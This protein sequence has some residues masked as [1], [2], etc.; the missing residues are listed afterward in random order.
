MKG[1]AVTI[2]LIEKAVPEL[3]Q[4]RDDLDAFHAMVRDQDADAL[5]PW[6]TRASAGL[7]ASFVNGLRRDLD[8]VRAALTHPWSSGQV[9][10]Q[11]TK[12]KAVKRQMYGRGN[13]DLLFARVA[14]AI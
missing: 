14:Q 12:V 10:G 8:A 4:A 1:Q 13:I 3:L 2:A 5:D 7:L 9:E 6:M 11:N